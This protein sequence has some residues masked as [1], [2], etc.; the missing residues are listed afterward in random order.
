[1]KHSEI[2]LSVHPSNMLPDFRVFFKDS[3]YNSKKITNIDY[4]I[5][6]TEFLP[7]YKLYILNDIALIFQEGYT[8]DD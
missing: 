8:C 6:Q 5:W 4:L 1:M 7:L 3:I 2:D